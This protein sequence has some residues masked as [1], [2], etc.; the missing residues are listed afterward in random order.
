MKTEA[1]LNRALG[2]AEHYAEES[3]TDGRSFAEP[4]KN[5]GGCYE[6]VYRDWR[7]L[8]RAHR[9]LQ[10]KLEQ[11]SVAWQQERAQLKDELDKKEERIAR[12]IKRQARELRELEKNVTAIYQRKV[13]DA[14]LLNAELRQEIERFEEWPK[15]MREEPE[16]VVAHK[17]ALEKVKRLETENERLEKKLAGEQLHDCRKVED[18][19]AAAR[20]QITE[21]ERKLDEK[22]GWW[23]EMGPMGEGEFRLDRFALARVVA[24]QSS[25]VARAA[26]GK[27]TPS[28]ISVQVW[29]TQDRLGY[30]EAH[31]RPIARGDRLSGISGTRLAPAIEVDFESLVSTKRI[32]DQIVDRP[33][34]LGRLQADWLG[35]CRSLKQYDISGLTDAPSVREFIEASMRRGHELSNE[36]QEQPTLRRQWMG[37][38]RRQEQGAWLSWCQSLMQYDISGLSGSPTVR[39]VIEASMRRGHELAHK[40]NLNQLY[41][42]APKAAQHNCQQVDRDLATAK[43]QNAEFEAFVEKQSKLET[44]HF[45]AR[46]VLLALRHLHPEADGTCEEHAMAV[47]AELTR[48]R[49]D[50]IPALTLAEEHNWLCHGDGSECPDGCSAAADPLRLELYQSLRQLHERAS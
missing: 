44:D 42:K 30:I 28:P 19:L 49:H 5:L 29:F 38:G 18:Q 34:A 6:Q 43:L 25:S 40:M 37:D 17:E 10:G 39:V 2:I 50:S 14:E 1:E 36:V 9:E 24:R 13:F 31:A 26:A 27:L 11:Q 48:L 4:L 12:D 47:A 41:G 32:A 16:I 15:K 20:E 3:P 45:E 35:W 21:L 23:G 7:N 8:Q 33:G 46:Q 22:A